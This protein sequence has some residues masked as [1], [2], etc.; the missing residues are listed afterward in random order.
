MD[1]R[2]RTIRHLLDG[3][4]QEIPRVPALAAAVGLSPSRLEHLFRDETKTT[5]RDYV[6]QRRLRLAARM[7]RRSHERISTIAFAVGFND[8]SNFNHAFKR[9]FGRSPREY[10]AAAGGRRYG[11]AAGRTK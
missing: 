4:L 11:S 6:K 8:V 7:L 1:P 3:N 10:R 5:I 2:I 9:A